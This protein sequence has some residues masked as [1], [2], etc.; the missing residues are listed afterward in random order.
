METARLRAM[1]ERAADKQAELDELR[2]RRYQEAKEREWRAKE[3]SFAERQAALQQELSQARTAQQA[4]KLKQKAEMAALEHDEF[5]RVLDVNRQKEYDEL[6][7]VGG[8]E[9]GGA[10][11]G[12]VGGRGM[13]TRQQLVVG[14]AQVP[15]GMEGKELAVVL[16]SA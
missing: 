10:G 4:A 16:R 15:G 14:L 8:A 1:Q 9:R 2:A 3:R 11:R 5:M 7:Q 13:T 6:Q 12:V